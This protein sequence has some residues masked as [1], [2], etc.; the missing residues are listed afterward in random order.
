MSQSLILILAVSVVF[1]GTAIAEESASPDVAAAAMALKEL[2]AQVKEKDGKLVA[3]DFVSAKT[4]ALDHLQAIREF[5]DLELIG[6]GPIPLTNG[7]FQLLRG[8]PKLTTVRVSARYGGDGLLHLDRLETVTRVDF[9]DP[10]EMT[11]A[12]LKD[13]RFPRRLE[14]LSLVG[15]RKLT[16]AGMEPLGALETLERLDLGAPQ[17][18]DDG[19]LDLK[20]LPKIRHL[21]LYDTGVTGKCFENLPW[22]GQIRSLSGRNFNDDSMQYLDG[23]AEL[24]RLNLS[25]SKVTDLGVERLVEKLPAIKHLTLNASVTDKGIAKLV[26]LKQLESINL[27]GCKAITD[28]GFRNLSA[29]ENLKEVYLVDCKIGPDAVAALITALPE[30]K[31]V[32]ERASR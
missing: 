26:K 27:S 19:L 5:R 15:A 12:L 29:L 20:R 17:V 10:G 21:S 24:E 25:R 4:A 30:A 22:R 16:N 1:S 31:I 3:V 11:D 28:E 8:F 6:T 2:G 13:I 7:A 14:M 18:T 9:V 23:F 32:S